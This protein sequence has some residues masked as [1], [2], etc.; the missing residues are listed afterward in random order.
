MMLRRS[1]V[2]ALLAAIISA[3]AAQNSSS[4]SSQTC[5]A[6]SVDNISPLV[7]K[8]EYAVRGRLLARAMELEAVL[9][10][11]G[12]GAAALPFKR[13]V[14]CN[15]G[16]PQAVGQKPTTFVRQV[17]SLVMNPA[18]LS[19]LSKWAYPKDAIARAKHY[20]AGI[21]SL[22]AYSDSQ[23][24]MSVR[25]EVADFIAARDGHPASPSDIFLTDGASAGVKALMQLLVRGPH[26]AV[27]VP[28]PQ[29]P[30]YSAVTTLLNGTLAPYY[31]DE[32]AAWGV[33]EAELRR[34]LTAAKAG[35]A[36]TRALC[37]INP[38]NPTG[39]SLPRAAVES[40]LRFAAKEKLVLMAD[41]VYQEN[42]YQDERPFHS[43][44]KTLAGMGEP[45]A[46]G[47][48]LLSFHTV[49]KGTAGECA[50]VELKTARFT[51]ATS[52]RR[53]R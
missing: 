16:N 8:A 1:R 10:A 9:K 7:V 28:V 25:K 4:G 49:S 22:G 48:E 44:R 34:A 19:G 20:L 26:D 35:G 42:V 29:Y 17:L 45:Y 11:G 12:D 36:T 5:E 38:G 24:I 52:P 30:L 47:V 21:P 27:L 33:Q 15:I 39:Q 14:R 2:M 31:L 46:S 32:D 53:A 37:V 40:I 50:R 41:E 18:Q 3:A 51:A 13:I 23:G 6:L 43:M